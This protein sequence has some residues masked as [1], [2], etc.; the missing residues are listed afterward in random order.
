MYLG[1]SHLGSRYLTMDTVPCGQLSL[2]SVEWGVGDLFLLISTNKLIS[3][4]HARFCLLC[5]GVWDCGVGWMHLTDFTS[6]LK[7]LFLGR[8]YISVIGWGRI[9]STPFT[10]EHSR[11][12][13]C[14]SS[15]ASGK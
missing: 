7:G 14:D 2:L 10:Y 5:M 4:D 13:L 11:S 12:S 1:H 6:G 9:K 3:S 8:I 15:L